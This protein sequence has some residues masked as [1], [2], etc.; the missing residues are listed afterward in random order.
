MDNNNPQTIDAEQD[1]ATTE[2][3]VSEVSEVQPQGNEPE[4]P[5]IDPNM[6]AQVQEMMDKL[7]RAE[8]LERELNEQKAKYLRLLA[9]FDGYRRRMAQEVQDAQGLGIAKAAETLCPILDDLSRAVELGKANPAS[10]LGGVE[11]VLDSSYRLFEKLDLYATG[12]EGEIFDPTYHEALSVV[13][14]EVDDQIVQVYQRGFRLGEKLV[15]PAR[16]VVS[17]R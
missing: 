3:E 5:E 12:N 2:V 1:I 6:F 7:E 14:G 17:K 13:P 16:V 9:E 15:R 4:M 8:T 11:Q 10:V